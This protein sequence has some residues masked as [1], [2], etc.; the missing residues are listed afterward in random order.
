MTLRESKKTFA[1]S[2]KKEG[3]AYFFFIIHAHRKI[4]VTTI[5]QSKSFLS[6]CS[7]FV[8]VNIEYLDLLMK[9]FFGR[10]I[11]HVLYNNTH[12]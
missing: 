1:I 8:P 12:R 2:L 4:D 7:V 6:R 5:H 10:T 11:A 3:E 9:M